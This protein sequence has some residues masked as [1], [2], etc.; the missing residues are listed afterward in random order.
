MQT[1]KC[2]NELKQMLKFVRERISAINIA[3][4][5]EQTSPLDVYTYAFGYQKQG[6]SLAFAQ[7]V[8]SALF[9]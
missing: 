1:T 9:F 2:K 7:F 5:Y 4:C 8:H 3:L 6:R